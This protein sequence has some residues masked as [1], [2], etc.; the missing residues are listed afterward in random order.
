MLRVGVVTIFP[1]MFDAVTRYGVS[2]RAVDKG[3]LEVL[4][5][6]PREFTQDVHRSVDD[7]PYGGGP[8]MVMLAE[9]LRRAIVA[10]RTA[11]GDA[12]VIYLTPQGE[13]VNQAR[14]RELASGPPV[15]M[16]AGRY[17]GVDER[18]IESDV[19]CELSIGDYVLSGGELAAMVLVDAAA[20]LLP[21]ALGHEDSAG[22]DSFMNGLLDHPQFTR[23]PVL[24]GVGV[25][26]VLL[27]GDHALVRRW[28]RKQSLGRTWLRRPELL[29]DLDLDDEQRE[30]LQEFIREHE[31]N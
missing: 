16:I 8:G 22:E 21:G 19:D 9:P 12:R 26:E 31:Q 14:V 27:S 3:L 28:R 6:N 4:L 1:E 17:E 7:R 11:L 20:R 29:E 23:P 15:I 24:D 10:A 2:G 13:P 30:L 25:P 5:F 18:L